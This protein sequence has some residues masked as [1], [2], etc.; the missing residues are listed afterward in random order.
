VSTAYG[1]D[2]LGGFTFISP[3]NISAVNPAYGGEG[4]TII[5]TG[6]RLSDFTAVYVA[7][8][9]AMYVKVLSATELQVIVGENGNPNDSTIK[10]VTPAG[11]AM[12]HGFHYIVKPVI[13]SFSPSSGGQGTIVTITG[14]GFIQGPAYS[15]VYK[16]TFG[17]V[18]A[19]SFNIVSPDTIIATVGAGASG[20]VSVWSQ[21]GIPWLDG[22]TFGVSNAPL[23]TSFS[24][25]AAAANTT[26][27]IRGK[28]FTGTTAVQFGNTPAASFSVLSDSVINAV[29][30][31]GATGAVTVTTIAGSIALNGFTYI[32]PAPPAPL[33]YTFSP[34]TGG[35]GAVI[36]IR[37]AH[38]TG[39]TAVSFG[40][41]A[42]AA[43]TVQSDSLI[44][45]TVG[46]GASGLIRVSGPNGSASI[47]T[48]GYVPPPPPPPVIAS[49]TPASGG[50]G[51]VVT[52][53]GSYLSAATAVT[54]GGTA[55]ASFSSQGDSMI[56]ATIGN[57]TSGTVR[58]V[59]PDGIAMKGGFTYIPPKPVIA[60]FTPMSGGP[61]TVVTIRGQ[62]FSNTTAVRFGGTS[63][64]FTIQ[65]DSVINAYVGYGASGEVSVIANGRMGILPGFTYIPPAPPSPLISGFTPTSADSGAVVM[66][67][68]RY[69]TNASAVLFGGVPAGSFTV[70]SDTT[71]SAVVGAGASGAV[72][73]ITPVDT[74]SRAG[75]TYL[76]PPTPAPTP[77]PVT[78][79]PQ[80]STISL[81]PN[82]ANGYVWVDHPASGK[83]A[84][85]RITD[86]MGNL[87]QL[88][89]VPAGL[90][91]TQLKTTSIPTGYY[92]ITWSDGS[93]SIT[94]GLMVVQ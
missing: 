77:A 48:F 69:F 35:P 76:P 87:L 90:N 18:A 22:F 36:T 70:L 2:T 55:A 54:F 51:T 7:G 4:R 92:R 66:I 10:V 68:G 61:G 82:P 89:T 1:T 52:I 19:A 93:T 85:L 79:A 20:G 26:V 25:A 29:V 67:R 49:F 59:T 73:V 84:Q 74:A 28:Y 56:L 62:Y 53:R 8:V 71:I 13:T 33:I 16:V 43:F 31:S 63:A 5:L 11:T 27:T 15:A 65:S 83:N 21:G 72:S 3:V 24:P 94:K 86:M 60:S 9:P 30:D 80:T 64:S 6:T 57:G 45:A 46:S 42:A 32:P 44:T 81:Y 91:K 78:P 12:Y 17:D 38:L 40:G 34:G 37:G 50:T 47:G 75:F 88:I 14:S 41:T 39:I 58:V 23:L